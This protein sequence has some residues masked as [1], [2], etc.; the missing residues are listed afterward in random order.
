MRQFKTFIVHIAKRDIFGYIILMRS[1]K[2][3]IKSGSIYELVNTLVVALLL[4]GL[5]RTILFQPFWIPTGSMK[6]NLLVGDFLF[7]NKFSYGFSR[8]SCP[9]SLCPIAGRIFFSEPKRG[10]VVVFRHPRS[11][12]D[13]IKRLIGLPGDKIK[14]INGQ[15]IINDNKIYKEKTENFIDVD[16]K[17]SKKRL[18][19]YKEYFFNKE[20]EIKWNEKKSS[21][22][23]VYLQI[24]NLKY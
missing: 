15:I 5:I 18:R 11:G 6:P 13:Y 19:K 8:Y 1:K 4:A 21:H 2:Q 10:D 14:I 24:Q 7:V 17:G 23:N 16:K 20:F 3:N 12:K 9:F 22:L